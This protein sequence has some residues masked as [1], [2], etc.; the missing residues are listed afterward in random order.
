MSLTE[1]KAA[2]DRATQDRALDA[3]SIRALDK[4]DLNRYRALR[5]S[6]LQRSPLAFGTSYEEENAFS[7]AMFA[8]RLEQV[9][10]NRLFG[11]FTGEELIGMAGIF[12]HERLSERHRATL[13]HVYVADEMRGQGIATRLVARC[14][15]QAARQFLLLDAKVVESNLSA[16]RVYH[17]LGF[18]TFGVEPK[19]VY[20]QGQF[21]AQELIYIDFTEPQWKAMVERN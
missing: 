15:E 11:A 16:K 1:D 8:R 17:G 13:Y 18:K 21:L 4:G 2:K 12:A 19:S 6:A 14:I 7:D 9:N 3:I 10:G 5:L 20:V